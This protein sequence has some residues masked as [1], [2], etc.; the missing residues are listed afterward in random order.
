M[1]PL[2][3]PASFRDAPGLD[4][5]GPGSP[6]SEPGVPQLSGR[7][8]EAVPSPRGRGYLG[9]KKEMVI[10]STPAKGGLPGARRG[11]LG[12]PGAR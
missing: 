11:A 7:A 6:G 3:P 10:F 8:G 5:G 9:G 1:N 2:S 12:S 4:A